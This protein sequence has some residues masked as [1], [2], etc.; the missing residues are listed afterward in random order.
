MEDTPDKTCSEFAKKQPPLKF[1]GNMPSSQI[2]TQEHIEKLKKAQN[3][4][5][6]SN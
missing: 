2:K 6:K 1:M 4:I 3:S 5:L